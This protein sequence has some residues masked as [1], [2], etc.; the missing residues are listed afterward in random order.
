MANDAAEHTTDIEQVQNEKKSLA[1]RCEVKR[2]RGA[3]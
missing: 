2:Y 3:F 1:F